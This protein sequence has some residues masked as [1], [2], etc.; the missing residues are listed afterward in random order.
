MTITAAIVLYS[1]I[2]FMVFFVVLPL[3]LVTQGETGEIVPGTPRSA[4]AEAQIGRKAKITTLW[5]TLIF[6]V[7]AGVI[8]SGWITVRD[9]DWVGRMDPVAAGE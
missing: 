3:R 2:W 4:P 7:V 1:V 9:L 6:V 8:L 5:A